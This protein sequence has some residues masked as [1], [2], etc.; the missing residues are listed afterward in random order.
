MGCVGALD[1]L[2]RSRLLFF[3]ICI[4]WCVRCG[5]FSRTQRR[6][7]D[8]GTLKGEK[9]FY[10]RVGPRKRKEREKISVWRPLSCHRQRIATHA[11]NG[12]CHLLLLST[13]DSPAAGSLVRKTNEIICSNSQPSRKR[14]SL[15]LSLFLSFPLKTNKRNKSKCI[16]I[17]DE[18]EET[19][20]GVFDAHTH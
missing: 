12:R 4:S 6:D 5:F 15:S 20:L 11:H 3:S 1:T 7:D 17:E 8:F 14:M 16:T 18:M 10:F 2:T 9:E 13:P 19:L